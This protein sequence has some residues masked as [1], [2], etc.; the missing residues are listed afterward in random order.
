MRKIWQGRFSKETDKLVE[1]FTSSISFDARLYKYDIQGSIAHAKMLAKCRIISSKEAQKIIS[2]LKQIQKEIESGKFEFKLEREDIHSNIEI[3]LIEKIGEV[4]KKLHTARSRNDQVILDLRLF[5]REEI[6]NI[7]NLIQGLQKVFLSR[8]EEDLEVI[9]PAYTHLQQAQPISLAHYWLAQITALERDEERLRK[10]Y[11]QVNVLPLG[12]CALAGTSFPIDR[13]LVAEELNFPAISTNSLDTVAERD[14]VID[15]LANTSLLMLHLS[16]LAEDLILWSTTEFGLVELDDAFCTGSSIMPQ[17][18]NPDVLELI[19]GKTARVYGHLISLLTLL[20]GLPFTYNRDLQED[21]IPLFETV[22]IVKKSL[23]I[24]TRILPSLQLKKERIEKVLTE[25]FMTMPDVCD[26]L[27]KQG[28]PF[29]ES[30]QICGEIVKYCLFKKIFLKDL[31]L[32]EFKSFHPY[33]KEDVL[34]V[35]KPEKSVQAK[36]SAGGT[37][38]TEIRKVIRRY[39]KRWEK[40]KN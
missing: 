3:S 30:Y 36:K 40:N 19:R 16:R 4:G 39:K 34:E 18:K 37:G 2:G 7:L 23:L 32:K 17:K 13:K 14:F 28:I 6:E 10:T 38:L 11:Q 5:L 27:T 31:S 20:K 26:Y 35:V 12:A 33:F 29:R 21:K 1:E 22:E 24:Y 15:F 9:F 25:S 8:A